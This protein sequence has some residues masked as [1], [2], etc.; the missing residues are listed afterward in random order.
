MPCSCHLTYA[1]GLSASR[2]VPEMFR[3]HTVP[4]EWNCGNAVSLK[5]WNASQW[6]SRRVICGTE[7]RRWRLSNVAV[8]FPVGIGVAS[9]KQ[10]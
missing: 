5:S 6:V 1:V 2:T 4:V 8:D 9:P 7:G 3:V 10:R